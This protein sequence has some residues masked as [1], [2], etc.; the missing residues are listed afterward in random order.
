[1]ASGKQVGLGGWMGNLIGSE[2]LWLRQLEAEEA[3]ALLQGK[4]DPE[5]PWMAGYPMQ[6][7]LIAVEAFVR[8][9]DDGADPGA[10]GV[11]SGAVGGRPGGGGHRLSR[12]ARQRGSVTVGYGLAP[13]ARGVGYATEALRAVVAWALGQPEV[14]AVEADTTHANLPSQ[15]VME[16]AGMRLYDRSDELGSP[17]S[18][19]GGRRAWLSAHPPPESREK[20]AQR[21]RIVLVGPPGAGKGTQAG[22]IVARFGGVHIATG[23]ILRSNAERGTSWA[24]ASRYVDRGDLVPDEVMIDMALERM[25]E[26][27]CAE[28]LRARRVP[29]N[30]PPGRGPRAAA[31]G[32]GAPARRGGQLR[33]RRGRAARPAGRAGRGA[34][35][36][37]G[38]RRGRHPAPAEAVRGNETEP[39]L[40]FYDGRGLLVR[41][42][43]QGRPGRGHRA[44]RHRPWRARR[45]RGGGMIA[46]V[47]GGLQR[48]R[49]GR[50]APTGKQTPAPT[51]CSWPGAANASTSSPA[52]WAGPP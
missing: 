49:G 45:P 29:A 11:S 6:G 26:G 41:D 1:M 21:M 19:S 35:P 38:R 13:G 27:D 44:G 33:Y 7:T 14:A 23:D 32:A 40:D 22:R 15:R 16:R 5:R 31:G 50:R 10:Y 36:G 25:G 4:A 24:G 28:R 46:L 51:W 9:V 39:L 42:R 52:S 12:A 2:R 30:R 8:A 48:A 18:L 3:R 47:T 20:G 43:G 37:R 34:G 17:G